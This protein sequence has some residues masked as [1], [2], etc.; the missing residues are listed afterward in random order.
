MLDWVTAPRARRARAAA[1]RPARGAR[2][3]CDVLIGLQN[4]EA[5]ERSSIFSAA[6]D[7]LDAYTCTGRARRRRRDPN[8]DADG[9]C[10]PSDTIYIHAP[11][12]TRRMAAPLVCG[13]LGGDPPRHL[14]RP[15]H[16]DTSAAGCCSR[17]MRSRT[18]HRSPSFR[19]R[20]RRR[21][22]RPALL[23]VAPGPQP[24]PRP[25][26]TVADGFLTLFGTKLILPGVADQR[27]LGDDLARAG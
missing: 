24:S 11:A 17:W 20:L 8:F 3:R 26:G 6:A 7:A 10:A 14:P 4:T 21:R 25:W 15:R 1:P 5:R 12:E 22:P 2:W 16:R 18:S 9:S 13:L 19:D 23:A 27:T